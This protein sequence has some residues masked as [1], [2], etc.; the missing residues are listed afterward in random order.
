MWSLP[1]LWWRW[2]RGGSAHSLSVGVSALRPNPS[3][4]SFGGYVPK[5]DVRS[6]A[7]DRRL[8]WTLKTVRTPKPE[9]DKQPFVQPVAYRLPKQRVVTAPRLETLLSTLEGK[10]RHAE[11][12]TEVPRTP[13]VADLEKH[14][15]LFTTQ[16]LQEGVYWHD[17]ELD[18]T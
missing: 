15:N 14:S 3:H 4:L 11:D 7:L 5:A 17:V 10:Q 8:C 13:L 2:L 12:K 16:S 6:M 9:C 1:A 18:V